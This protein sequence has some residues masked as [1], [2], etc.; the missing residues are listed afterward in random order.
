MAEKTAP[1]IADLTFRQAIAE[2][3]EIVGNLEGNTLELEDSIVQ[4]ERGVELLKDLRKRLDSAQQK[5]DVL[6]GELEQPADDSAI[7]TTLQKA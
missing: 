2:L 4:Y 1:K 7:D 5:V 6:M 3:D